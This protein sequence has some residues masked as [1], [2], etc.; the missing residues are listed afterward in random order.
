MMVL[1]FIAVLSLLVPALL[2]L[3]G[4]GLHIT[5]PVIE[6]RVEMYAATSA[7]DAAIANGRVDPDIGAAGAP[8]PSRVLRV[9][10]LDVTVECDNPPVPDDGCHTVDRFVVFRAEVRRP[11]SAEVL[12]TVTNE[13]VYRFDP[14]G[15]PRTEV[16]QYSNNPAAPVT[17]VPIPSC[18]DD[19]P[20]PTTTTTT[21]MPPTTTTTTMPPTT[22]ST[23]T[24]STSTTTT[25]TPT[26]PVLIVG[27]FT[28][29]GEFTST[30]NTNNWRAVGTALVVREDGSAVAGATVTIDVEHLYI[31]KK[32]TPPT[33]HA[34][35]SMTATTGP[36]GLVTFQTGQLS[37]KNNDNRIHAVRFT[38]TQVTRTGH[39]WTGEDADLL[40]QEMVPPS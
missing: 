25:T 24:T 13:V 38:I 1:A 20:P 11:G 19:V 12:A 22:T 29:E 40:V 5:R 21:T 17:T 2:T 16:R 9:N 32:S 35:S 3:T 27:S 26:T 15:R 37:N 39:D 4:T 7:L 31:D 18:R 36:D 14:S 33:W 23:T 34:K 30:K 8:C 10:G 28:G 6:D